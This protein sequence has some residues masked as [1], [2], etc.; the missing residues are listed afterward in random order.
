MKP[1]R[2]SLLSVYLL[3]TVGSASAEVYTWT[4]HQGTVHFTDQRT[5][6]RGATV[7]TPGPIS[8]VPMHENLEAGE[9]ITATVQVP[10][11]AQE[12]DQRSQT[13]GKER[14]RCRKYRRQLAN[15]QSQLRAGYSNAKGNSLRARRR[16]L[17][18][19][20]SR[21]CILGQAR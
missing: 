20:L 21:E 14:N 13:Q 10:V 8:I 3:L 2:S 7:V 4:D 9:A 18:A 19:R 1:G 11:H 15:I 12:R 17:N 5:P 6:G 16:K